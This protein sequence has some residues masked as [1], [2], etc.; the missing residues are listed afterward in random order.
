LLIFIDK[1]TV[2]IFR[3]S[4]NNYAINPSRLSFCPLQLKESHI[5]KP[6]FYICCM[7][8]KLYR[9][10][11]ISSP[12]VSLVGS[13][14]II[15]FEQIEKPRMFLLWLV[16][17]CIVFL[18]WNVNIFILSKIKESNSTKRYILSYL[19]I[20][21]IQ[22]FNIFIAINFDLKPPEI[23]AF[24]PFLPAI[25]INTLIL[26]LSNLIILQFQK[27]SAELEV[28][29]LKVNN[30]EAQKMILL[31]QLQP[32]FLFNALST[33]KSLISENPT[34]AEDYTVRLSDFLR[35]SVQ[36][37]NNE[38]VTLFDELAFTKNYLELQKV[39]FEDSFK[40]Q[41]N[42]PEQYLLKKIPV[43]ALQTLVENAIK[44]NSFTEKKP[45]LIEV[46]V[47]EN[48]L[49]VSN[50]ILPKMLQMQ[51]GTGLKNLNQRYQLIAAKEI[52]I[53]KTETNFTVFIDLL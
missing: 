19:S 39:R 12:V 21:C 10:A 37:K 18:F 15:I 25:A 33:L 20:L 4:S 30:L 38:V 3:L 14:P 27:E 52:K 23:N 36:A 45:L 16:L 28:K 22:T 31:Q 44:H 47:N 5:Q 43:Y 50:N 53:V 40:C 46:S 34:N 7:K 24:F 1:D 29:Q 2:Y 48:R 9:V 32:H 8:Q 42:I 13:V 49:K 35:Y 41:I 17:A 26:I 51:S 11:L 6:I